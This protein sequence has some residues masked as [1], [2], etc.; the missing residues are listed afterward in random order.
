MVWVKSALD[1][2]KG[3]HVSHLMLSSLT[4][5]K[6]IQ[7]TR[8]EVSCTQPRWSPDGEHIAFVAARPL[9]KGTAKGADGD[10]KPEAQLW[11]M[12]AF[13]GEP[14][15]LTAGARSVRQH[16]WA[17][18]ETLVFS[19]QED[20]SLY[21]MRAKEKK[22]ASIAVDDEEH[23][24]PVRLFKVAL[25][26]TEVARLTDNADRIRAFWLSPD[27]RTVVTMH[28][29]SL[30]HE[31][32]QRIKPRVCLV[33]LETGQG[34]QILADP[35]F[36]VQH[37]CWSRDGAG[38]YAISSYSR[39]PQYVMATIDELYY[40]D[41]AQSSPVQVDLDWENGLVYWG[42]AFDVTQD[43]FVALLADGARPRAAR[44]TRTGDEWHRAWLDGEHAGHLFGLRVGDDGETFVYQYTTASQ[45][46]Q[47]YRARLDGTLV[48]DP[49]QI[50][51]INK[52]LQKRTLA[53]TEIIRWT[54]SRDEEVE[55]ILYYP[56]D[57]QPGQ[58][59]P[60]VVMIHG[61][62]AWA[63]F[64][65]WD[66]SWAY[67]QNLFNQRGAF[68]LKPNYH[69]SSFYGLD[70]VTSIA[71]GMYYDLEVPDIERGVDALIERGLV[72]P[73]RLGA[74][75]W[76]N[77]AIL[78]IALAVTTDRYRVASAGA[79]DVDWTSD[80]ANCGFGAAFDGY[81]LGASP[82]EDP[83]RYASKSPF[84]KL[85]RVRTPTLIFFGD[86]DTAVPT[87]QGWMHFRALQQL[88][89]TDVRFVLF[90]GEK[91]GLRKLFAQRRKLEEELAWFDKYLFEATASRNPA[92]KPN[93]PLDVALK[94]ARSAQVDG[95]YGIRV[96][97]VLVPETVLYK[98]LEI[99]RFE[100]TCAQYA[101]FDRNWPVAPGKENYPAGGV[102]FDQARAYCEWLSASS[103]E[104]YRLGDAEEMKDVYP[105]KGAGNTLNYWAGYAV[106][107]DD[108]ARLATAIAELGDG[109]PLLREVGS[110]DCTETDAPV[111]DL[112]GNVAEWAIAGDG[113]GVVLG[114]SADVP[115]DPRVQARQRA[116][117]Y[118]GFRVV[119]GARAK[120]R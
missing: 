84:F 111:F 107:P 29:R 108:A 48:I 89:Q 45:P 74:M 64:D 66:D 60:L 96:S 92:L 85:D 28:E 75:G 116:P 24:P 1:T 12:H 31:Y 9:P 17:D 61:G 73:E 71:D 25:K 49:V 50:T 32:D 30:H 11:V 46:G 41:L 98:G 68:V 26:D 62:P 47:W 34:Q 67:P 21:E 88:G 104:V 114:G 27:G 65:A 77:G 5:G 94:R 95:A 109:A 3:E 99:G 53:R 51:E 58:S 59:C 36:N 100:V 78:T 14:W 13:G 87:Q 7:L 90:P 57:F 80:W 97:G 54:G 79:G 115:A 86:K 20:R 118:T 105:N 120:A 35:R 38:F 18:A 112:G 19:A 55:G 70:W 4:A 82:L 8:G 91:H 16:A 42:Q 63:D 56:H 110:L 106:N 103:G 10:E 72:D 33:D 69:G 37:V 76:S 102:T 23:E 39:H 101:A 119:K 52:H 113:E 81:Y 6:E 43:G 44:Y 15:H 83:Q 22:D 117:A 93:S 2:E 40:Y